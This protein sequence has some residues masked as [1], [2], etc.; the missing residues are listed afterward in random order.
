M[1]LLTSIKFFCDSSAG[2]SIA[3]TICEF[4]VW[5]VEPVLRY[6]PLAFDKP[7][8]SDCKDAVVCSI[9]LNWLFCTTCSVSIEPVSTLSWLI[10]SLST[11]AVD[12]KLL[13]S[14]DSILLADKGPD[15]LVAEPSVIVVPLSVILESN[16]CLCTPALGITLLDKLTSLPLLPVGAVNKNED[17]PPS[18]TNIQLSF[19]PSHS[20]DAVAL[21]EPLSYT[22]N[23]AY[24]TAGVSALTTTNASPIILA[25]PVTE[26]ILPNEP[27]PLT[28]MF[29]KFCV[30]L[31]V[32][33]SF[34]L[35]TE[36]V[37][38]ALFMVVTPLTVFAS[39]SVPPTIEVITE[40]LTIPPGRL[41]SSG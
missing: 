38:I 20:I 33:F 5:K 28:D 19:N 2:A 15:T 17:C 30:P 31:N 34:V 26:L 13:I 40:P 9:L 37:T 10:L 12:S 18:S 35:A 24:R 29:K 36:P 14:I 25:E 41:D 27:V 22:C 7:S 16:N 1:V 8:I 6:E 3:C 21:V 11:E 39:I 4:F 23:P 32:L